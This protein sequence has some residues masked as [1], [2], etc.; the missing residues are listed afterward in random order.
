MSI[1]DGRTVTQPITPKITPFAMTS[2][3]SFPSVKVIKQSAAKPAT[4]VTE[5]PMTDVSVSLIAVAIA[6]LLLSYFG[7]C[8]L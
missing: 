6:S 4:V 7:S 3:R 8:S 2:P 5:L 1:S